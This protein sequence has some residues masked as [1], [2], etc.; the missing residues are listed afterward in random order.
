M[1][2]DARVRYTKKVLRD[3]L[4]ECIKTKPLKSVTVKEIC[5]IAGLNRAT[6][7]NH[8]RDCYDLLDQL[9]NEQLDEFR[10]ILTNKNKFGTEIAEAIFDM[11][12][13]NK[14]MNEAAVNGQI[15]D[16]LKQKMIE[17]ARD[18]SIDEWHK[19]M[20][21]ATKNRV[22]M[23]FSAVTASVFQI[24]ICESG[25]YDRNAIVEFTNKLIRFAISSCD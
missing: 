6:F 9:E 13:R 7:Y 2:N 25:N 23:V 4:F 22:E 1:A 11:I 15:S 14:A 3:A 20:P 21:G 24:A 16:N 8:Y 12:D 18:L 19:M 10:T 17:I 5:G